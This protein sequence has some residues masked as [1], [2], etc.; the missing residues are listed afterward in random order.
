MGRPS[1]RT[2]GAA[3]NFR[4]VWCILARTGHDTLA[5]QDVDKLLV[6]A[7]GL[8]QSLLEEDGSGDVLAETGCGHQQL[9]VCPAVVLCVLDANGV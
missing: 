2:V 7:G 1:D 6:L 8:I 3:A 4:A 9:T 5:V